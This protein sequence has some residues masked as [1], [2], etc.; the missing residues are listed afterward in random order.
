MSVTILVIE[1]ITRHF[2]DVETFV[3]ARCSALHLIKNGAARNGYVVKQI[4]G[5]ENIKNALQEYEEIGAPILLI[6][7]IHMEHEGSVYDLEELIAL[8]WNAPS[9]T[10]LGQVHIIVNSAFL[11]KTKHHPSRPHAIKVPKLGEGR[12]RPWVELSEAIRDSVRALK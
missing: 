1:D 5:E 3:D 12:S 7:D 2:E 10:W 8:I 9:T 6:F 4:I 11:R